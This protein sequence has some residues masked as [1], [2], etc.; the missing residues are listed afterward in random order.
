MWGSRSLVRLQAGMEGKGVP[1]PQ[2]RPG[3]APASL[4]AGEPPPPLGP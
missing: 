4:C 2:P 3:L 1:L